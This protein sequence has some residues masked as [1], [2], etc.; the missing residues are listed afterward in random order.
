MHTHL[1]FCDPGLVLL[2]ERVGGDELILKV[3]LELLKPRVE[4]IGILDSSLIQNLQHGKGNITDVFQ[5]SAL[6]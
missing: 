3:T 4:D 6:K 1:K 2:S 5:M